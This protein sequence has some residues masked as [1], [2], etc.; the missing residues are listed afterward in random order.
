MSDLVAHIK[1]ITNETN[2]LRA[3]VRDAEGV[4]SSLKTSG[5]SSIE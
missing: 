4:I 1:N 2:G 3:R 5:E